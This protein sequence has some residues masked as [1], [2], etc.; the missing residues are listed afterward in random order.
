MADE[1]TPRSKKRQVEHWKA[2]VRPTLAELHRLLRDSKL[3]QRTVEEG[4]GV[5]RGYLSQLLAGKRD[6]KLWHLL[7]VLEVLDRA[8][9][10]FFRSVFPERRYPALS[11]FQKTSRP[12]SPE[13][14]ELLKRLYGSGVAS[15]NDL[16]ER[17]SRCEEA[18]AELEELGLVGD[19]GPEGPREES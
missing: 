14:D 4:A 3:S 19:N 2:A 7:A 1:K 12:L 11:Y 5:S 10:E 8:P 6:L 9:G 16:R 13:T 15:L 18:L 17:L